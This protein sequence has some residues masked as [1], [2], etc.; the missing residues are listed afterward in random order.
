MESEKGALD[1]PEESTVASVQTDSGNPSPDSPEALEKTLGLVKSVSPTDDSL[2]Y[3]DRLQTPEQHERDIQ[4]T[5][6]LRS[7]VEA[8]KKKSTFQS[9]TRKELF[10]LCSIIVRAFS[11]LFVMLFLM[12]G[13]SSRPENLSDT[14][15]FVTACVSFLA[16]IFGLLTIITKY[17]FPEN[18]EEYIT[19]IME[20]IQ[21]ND[22]EHKLANINYEKEKLPKET[23][24]SK[25]VKQ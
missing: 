25:K 13:F 8:Y 6:L 7:Y 15:S 21:K 17:C 3:F 23:D 9:N 1:P 4:I 19:R 16:L 18:D 2:Y 5:A 20:S 14:V 12:V 22:L 24:N 10:D 11:A